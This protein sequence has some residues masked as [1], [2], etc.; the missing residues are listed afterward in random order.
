MPVPVRV[1][2]V[3]LAGLGLGVVYFGGLWLT[4][5][6]LRTSWHPA[7]LAFGSFWMRTA[8]VVAGF[9]FLAANGWQ[10]AIVCLA[11]FVFARP[12]L[13]RGMPGYRAEGRGAR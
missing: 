6:A 4:V 1:I 11:G 5:R 3:F 8:L 10:D 12:L 13:A 2:L 9:A 7:A